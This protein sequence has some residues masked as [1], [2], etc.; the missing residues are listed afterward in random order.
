MKVSNLMHIGLY[1]AS[2]FLF[3]RING[4]FGLYIADTYI[5]LLISEGNMACNRGMGIGNSCVEMKITSFFLNIGFCTAFIVFM[6]NLANLE[7]NY[8]RLSLSLR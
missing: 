7:I 2:S 6:I 3:L 5:F 8:Q 4:R 1:I